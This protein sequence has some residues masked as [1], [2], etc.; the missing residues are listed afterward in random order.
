M[1]LFDALTT[2]DRELIQNYIYKYGVSE[3]KFRGLENYLYDWAASKKKLYH[4]LGDQLIRKFPFKYEKD[5]LTIRN[6][7]ST[8]VTPKA[9]FLSA[10]YSKII[11]MRN[12]DKFIE[13]EHYEDSVYALRQL[14]NDYMDTHFVFGTVRDIYVNNKIGRTIK[15]QAQGNPKMLNLDGNMKPLKALQAILKYFDCF[16]ENK[17]Q[18]EALRL[19][20]SLVFNDKYLRGN[21]CISIHPLDFMTM[22]DN[23][24]NWH[25]CMNWTEEGCYRIGSVEMMTSNNVVCCYLE[26]EEPFVFNK[27]IET[28]NT[29]NNKKWRC[30]CY[31]TKDIIVSGKQYPYYSEPLAKSLVEE[32]QRLAGDNLHWGYEFNKVE[33]YR[34]MVH[35]CGM[36][37]MNRAKRFIREK[38]ATKHNIIFDTKGMYNDML[39]DNYFNYWCVRN[40]VPHTKVITYSG[41]APCLCCNENQVI[42]LDSNWEYNSKYDNVGAL[43]CLPCKKK[44]SCEVCGSYALKKPLYNYKGKKYCKECLISS[45]MVCSCCGEIKKAKEHFCFDSSMKNPPMWFFSHS[46]RVADGKS[47]Y[48]HN[49]DLAH[50]LT[51]PTEKNRYA[52]PICEDCLEELVNQGYIKVNHYK[53]NWNVASKYF[54]GVCSTIWDEEEHREF[55]EKY[56]PTP[57]QAIQNI[58]NTEEKKVTDRVKACKDFYL[59]NKELCETTFNE[60]IGSDE[61]EY[62]EYLESQTKAEEDFKKC[63]K[64]TIIP[65]WLTFY[66]AQPIFK[67]IDFNSVFESNNSF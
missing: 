14:I 64:D 29:W 20:H 56:L 12:D 28:N 33:P 13:I 35:I 41:K 27:K 58:L 46:Q 8:E 2:E 40:K 1:L 6:E 43:V 59:A 53:N 55:I 57:D 21:L 66:K 36:T 48:Y 16:E 38:T 30:L 24:S 54:A 45:F 47:L 32:I 31:V 63:L 51:A 15:V 5:T 37:S 26:S 3:D 19:A 62:Q 39:N 25:S 49:H 9:D 22:S 61:K 65:D 60:A 18:F 4:L 67:E 34:D 17:E 10:L 7:I 52:L 23:A 44:Y 50:S 42:E 11:D